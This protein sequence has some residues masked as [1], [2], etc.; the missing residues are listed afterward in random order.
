[1]VSRTRWPKEEIK[2]MKPFFVYISI[3]ILYN[4]IRGECMKKDDK[5]EINYKNL[6][7]VLD[8]SRGILKVGYALMILLGIY[9]VT[10]LLQEW[11]VTSFVAQFLQ[12]IAPLFVGFIIAWLFDPVVT[13]FNKK[14]LKR[15][16]G[17]SI[18]YAVL[19]FIIYVMLA[20]LLP[21]L[22]QQINEFVG[23]I[24]S[25]FDSIQGWIDRIFAGIEGSKSI[26][27]AEVKNQ[28]YT[29][30]ENFG[31]ELTSALPNMTVD[32]LGNFVSTIGT[33]LIGM[34]I[35]FYLLISFSSFN[36]SILPFVPKNFEADA[37]TLMDDIN[38]SLR[39]YVQG[40][41]LSATLVFLASSIGFAMS[42]LQAA[43][44]FGLFC[45][46][47]NIIP[48]IG[49]YIGGIPA[50]IVGFS[51]DVKTGILALVVVAVVQFF[52]S[53]FFQPIIMSKNLKLHPVT[54]M[55]GLL[56]FGYFWGIA[57]MVLATP[58]IAVVKSIY[59]FFS[60]KYDLKALI[61]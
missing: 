12:I 14:G 2:G 48:Y 13:Y 35:G 46:L 52:E 6:N 28:L 36:E 18:V 10:M 5:K 39:S 9:A 17:A 27:I 29:N 3:L 7:E 42:G 53:N 32:F 21:I 11:K 8:L 41:A 50:V 54:I 15:A 61:K 56:V 31:S 33:V 37:K 1:M 24:P 59:N 34:V 57:G 38:H 47:T 43:L 25:I 4:K 51:Q 49:P 26:D 58:I 60:E 23:V 40:I 19:L 16:F 22:S 55:V 44:L 30:M 20:T 45:G